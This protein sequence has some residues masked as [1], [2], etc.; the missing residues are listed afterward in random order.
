MEQ[1]PPKLQNFIFNKVFNIAEYR[2]LSREEQNIYD[3]S[4]KN[5]N[6]L[7]NS[8]NTAKADGYSDAENTYLPLLKKAQKEKEKERK[9]KEKAQKRE[10]EAKLREQETKTSLTKMIHKLL[11]KGFSLE[12]IAEDL[13][14]N[15]EEI[16]ELLG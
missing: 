3:E 12:E 2:S 15:V 4:L 11:A 5:Y 9:E 7:N 14:K 1:I 10:E 6:D 8:L 13:G 16:K